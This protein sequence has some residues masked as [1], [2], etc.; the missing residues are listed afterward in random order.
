MKN[1]Q[2]A[3]GRKIILARESVHHP[4]THSVGAA[5]RER[6][7]K[8]SA[9]FVKTGISCLSQAP[10]TLAPTGN[11]GCGY[12]LWRRRRRCEA[13]VHLSRMAAFAG[14]RATNLQW[15][16]PW[17]EGQPFII[18]QLRRCGA[19]FRSGP[20]ISEHGL[21]SRRTAKENRPAPSPP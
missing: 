20:V 2:N 21:R 15:A 11:G 7:K 12:L 14:C 5:R 8:D 3:A 19:Q 4:F 1:D 10:L 9:A 17:R 16:V 6:E 18:I 13:L